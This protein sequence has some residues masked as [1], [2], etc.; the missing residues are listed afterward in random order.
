MP[1]Q[2]LIDTGAGGSVA[3]PGWFGKVVM[4]GDFAHR[5]VPQDFIAVCDPWLS[6]SIAASRVQ[7]GSR[8]LDTYLTGPVW[9]FAWA[10]G[11]VNANWWFGVLM[12]SVDAVGRYFPLLVCATDQNPPMSTNAFDALSAWYAHAGRAALGTLQPGASLD[13]FE[14]ELAQ[15]QPWQETAATPPEVQATAKCTRHVLP[16]PA[17][18]G[19]WAHALAQPLFTQTYQR[20]SFWFA[21][22]AD[23]DSTADSSLTVVVGLPDPDQFSL[24]LEGRW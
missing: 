17:A 16:G 2:T 24:M 19:Q 23:A 15:A 12:P 1:G 21:S 8:W 3:V 11:V 22:Q 7:L 18:L 20:H 5:R 9:R 13:G 4:L 10:P 6:Q 14:A